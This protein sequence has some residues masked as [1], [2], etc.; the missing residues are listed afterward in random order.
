MPTPRHVSLTYVSRA[1]SLC[2]VQALYV[3]DVLEKFNDVKRGVEEAVT[4][5]RGA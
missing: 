2:C 1:D 5:A 4:I 3:M